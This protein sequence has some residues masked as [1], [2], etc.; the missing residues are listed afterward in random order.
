AGYGPETLTIYHAYPGVY[1]F[2]VVDYTDQGINPDTNLARSGAT[3]R[4]YNNNA[5]LTTM[6]VPNQPGTQWNLFT[7][8]GTTLTPLNTMTY[9]PAILGAPTPFR[10]AKRVKSAA[11]RQR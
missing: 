9:T 6:Y 3:V 11:A 1:T 8:N 10:G 5:L 7:W 2:F 4:M